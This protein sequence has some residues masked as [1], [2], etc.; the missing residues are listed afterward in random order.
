[1]VPKKILEE[2]SY[3][4]FLRRKETP[5]ESY[6]TLEVTPQGQIIQAYG[7]LDSKPDWEQIKPIVEQVGK[8]V[9]KRWK[10]SCRGKEAA[11]Y[12]APVA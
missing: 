8:E 1:M 3:I 2:T 7:F 12:V 11:T 5:D 10:A 9:E 6:Y 4:L